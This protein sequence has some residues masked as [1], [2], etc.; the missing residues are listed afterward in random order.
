[1]SFEKYTKIIIKWFST[2][3]KDE[4]EKLSDQQKV[5]AIINGIRVQDVQ[6]M[7]A[8]L[9]IAGQYLFDVMMVCAYF[10]REVARIHGSA[11][12]SGQTSCRKRHKIYSADSSGRGRGRFGNRGHGS[13]RGYGRSNGISHSGSGRSNRDSGGMSD[14]NGIVISNPTR[15]FTDKELTALGP[16]GGRAHVTQQRM[17]ING[18]CRGHDAGKGCQGRGITSVETGMEQEYV[19]EA[20]GRGGCGGR[21]G[22]RFGRGGYRTWLLRAQKRVQATP[23][24]AILGLILLLF[25]FCSDQSIPERNGRLYSYPK[26]QLE[27]QDA[28][29][30]TTTIQFK[31]I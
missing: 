29:P 25:L 11:Q 16:G 26:G 1:M 30:G 14:F 5:N 8:T 21:N 28:I 19:D 6:P 12:V 7:A 20:S 9:Y 15:S 18:R 3:D 23:S 24:L 10:S 31:G 22:V 17:M 13:G 27:R 2:L 4:D